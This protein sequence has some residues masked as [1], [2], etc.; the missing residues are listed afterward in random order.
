MSKEEY[1]A[2][3]SKYRKALTTDI[4]KRV[5]NTV[6]YGPFKGMKITDE[7]AWGDGDIASKLLGIYE[8]ELYDSFEDAI[9]NRPDLIV[10]VGCAEG[11]Y[12]IG[13]GMRLKDIPVV[14]IDINQ[15]LLTIA[16]K[17]AKINGI[18]N[19]KFISE[20]TP[21]KLESILATAS[22][23]LLIMDC[24]GAEESLLDFDKVPSLKKTAVIV[25]SHDILD[26]PGLCDK[27]QS[28]F[29]NTH[30][31]TRITQG[32]KNPYEKLIDDMSDWEK[33][34]ICVEARQGT[35][36]WLYMTPKNTV[37]GFTNCNMQYSTLI[38]SLLVIA[39][40]LIAYMYF[41]SSNS[42]A[43]TSGSFSIMKALKHY[44]FK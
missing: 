17:N 26:K 33:M 34:L 43:K 21:E 3:A 16:E 39:L 8:S 38:I 30:N 7:V 25:E 20:S 44:K 36:S 35:M 4:C 18:T 27:L 13:L 41:V 28:R 10:N 5:N 32:N 19:I 42:R 15:A 40:L 37:E 9:R 11:F 1:I 2:A 6:A 14:C 22:R 31:Q 23:P 29:K 12:A 24:E